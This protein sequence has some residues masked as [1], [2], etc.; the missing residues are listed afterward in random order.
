[1]EEP[2]RFIDVFICFFTVVMAWGLLCF[3]V[4]G[5]IFSRRR[6]RFF[7]E[8]F[9]RLRAEGKST[10]PPKP[11]LRSGV[12]SRKRK[13][14]LGGSLEHEWPSYGPFVIGRGELSSLAS[15]DLKGGSQ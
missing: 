8:H 10:V 6:D 5:I 12:D 2:N 11:R 13:R 7:K 4:A 15:S 14:A 3:F 9:A 1:M